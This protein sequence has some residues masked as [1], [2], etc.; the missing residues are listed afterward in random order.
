MERE[1]SDRPD[2]AQNQPNPVRV[3]RD[4]IA[5]AGNHAIAG[6]IARAEMSPEEAKRILGVRLHAAIGGGSSRSDDVVLAMNSMHVKWFLTNEQYDRTYRA[7]AAQNLDPGSGSSQTVKN[8]QIPDFVDGLARARAATPAPGGEKTGAPNHIPTAN[9]AELLG[10]GGEAEIIKAR[11]RRAE[12]TALGT[13]RTKEQEDELFQLSAFLTPDRNNALLRSAEARALADINVTPEEWFAEIVTI[14]FLGKP[15]QV[16][17][18]LAEKLA[19]VEQSIAGQQV[20]VARE[21]SGLRPPGS[22]LHGLGLAIDV[23]A[24][25]NP[26]IFNATSNEADPKQQNEKSIVRG[27][28]D[29][30]VLL[31]EQKTADV[32][33]FQERPAGDGAHERAEASYDK[34]DEASDA[35]QEYF[36]LGAKERRADL[37]EKVAAL[38][39][40]DPKKRTVDQW[41]KAIADDRKKLPAISASKDWAKPEQGFLDLDK[42]LVMAMVDAG[43]TWLGD[44]TIGGGRDIMHFDTRAAG[45][46]KHLYG[47]SSN[48]TWEKKGLTKGH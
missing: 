13:K 37:E 42:R 5:E 43:L 8:G 1:K 39:G 6:M 24:S 32:E 36:A 29:R 16:H 2:A 25:T 22:G 33:K 46:I 11:T 23:N 41:A 4:P 47:L 21:L 27:I 48:G 30:A 28:I 40:T 38:G 10:N 9:D 26:Y 17:K 15:V 45:P 34:L 3:Q 20:P 31:I 19:A 44:D 14:T 12:L 18:I 35:M 7:L